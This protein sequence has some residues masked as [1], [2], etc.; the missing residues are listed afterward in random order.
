M[1]SFIRTMFFNVLVVTVYFLTRFNFETNEK[2]T[3]EG[4]FKKTLGSVFACRLLLLC[5]GCPSCRMCQAGRSRGIFTC[6]PWTFYFPSCEPHGWPLLG[7][8]LCYEHWWDPWGFPRAEG[9][10]QPTREQMFLEFV[11]E[12][13]CGKQWHRIAWHTPVAGALVFASPLLRLST[14]LQIEYLLTWAYWNQR[15]LNM[16]THSHYGWFLPE[17]DFPFT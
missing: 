16:D 7:R 12:L 15:L 8:V 17:E 14:Q 10:G 11:N 1:K 5:K 9:S 3:V 6:N 13:G 2:V 4:V